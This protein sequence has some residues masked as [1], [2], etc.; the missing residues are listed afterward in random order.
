[1]QFIGDTV[2]F[3]RAAVED[4]MALAGEYGALTEAAR[5]GTV[6]PAVLD[7]VTDAE[8]AADLAYLEER[9]PLAFE[10]AADGIARVSRIVGAMREFAH[11]P[12]TR[13]SAADLNAAISNTLVVARNEYKYV[14][15]IELDLGDMPPVTCNIGDVNQVF[16][17]LIVNAAHAI[18]EAAGEGDAKGTITITS[19][20]DGAD[21]VVRVADTGC[22]IPE[23]LRARIFDPFFTTKPSGRGTGQGLAIARASVED[24]HGGLLGVESDPGRGTVCTIRLPL[25]GAPRAADPMED[26]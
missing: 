5:A 7:R 18:A 10:R 1:M 16:L 2:S 12:T 9:L 25:T 15:D 23:D 14:A 11:P 20:V 21:A 22:G 4:V 26:V 3:V 13:M 19:R 17:N 6:P 24:R 8:E